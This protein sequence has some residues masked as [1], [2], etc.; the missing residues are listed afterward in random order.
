MRTWLLNWNREEH[1]AFRELSS[2]SELSN[3]SVKQL[4]TE[5]SFKNI[6]FTVLNCYVSFP[7]PV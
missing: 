6:L 4:C 5:I 1:K 3:W 2:Y 7:V